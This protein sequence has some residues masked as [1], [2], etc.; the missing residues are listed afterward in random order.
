MSYRRTKIEYKQLG[1]YG[2]E[3][4]S[5]L[6]CQESFSSDMTTFYTED[7][8]VV[9]SFDD[10]IHPNIMDA[11]ISIYKRDGKAEEISGLEFDKAIMK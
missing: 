4:K 3:D 11:M 7:G 10:T 8:E 1:S 2:S 6:Y 9:F 5:I